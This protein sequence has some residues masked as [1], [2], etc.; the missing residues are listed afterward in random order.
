[1]KSARHILIGIMM[2]SS[3]TLYA[4]EYNIGSLSEEVKQA[5]TTSS[6]EEVVRLCDR[7][8]GRLKQTTSVNS[9]TLTRL[10]DYKA[11]SMRMLGNYSGAESCYKDEISLL[12]D[13]PTRVDDVRCKLGVLYTEMGL[14]GEAEETLGAVTGKRQKGWSMLHL[15]SLSMRR[16]D[17]EEAIERLNEIIGTYPDEEIQISAHQNLGFILMDSPQ[18]DAQESAKTHLRYAI[19]RLPQ[20]RLSY[21]T[22][23]GN[24]ALLEAKMGEYPA[25]LRHIN[26]AIEWYETTGKTSLTDYKIAIRKKGEILMIKGNRGEAAK[27]YR[28]Y[29]GIEK[30]FAI[31]RFSTMT[32]QNR[33]DF[34]KTLKPGVSKIFAIEEE[35]PDFL[36]DVSLF[37]REVTLLGDAEKSEMKRRL[38]ITGREITGALKRGEI[39]ID[40]VRYRKKD[41]EM[42][43]AIIIPSAAMNMPIKFLPLWEEEELHGYKIGNTLR[44]DEAMCSDYMQDKNLLYTDSTL[45]HYIWDALDREL[46]KYKCKDIYFVPD[47]ILHLLAI[48]YMRQDDGVTLHRIST[49]SRLIDRK[50]HTISPK[51]KMLAAGGLDFDDADFKEEPGNGINHDAMNYLQERLKHIDRPFSYLRGARM[52][53][54]S[55]RAYSAFDTD[56]TTL[57]TE[58]QLKRAIKGKKYNILHLSTHGY[59]LDV[60]VPEMPEAIRDS[61]TEDRSLLASGIALTGANVAYKSGSSEDGIISA[62]EFCEMDLRNIDLI[63]L[64]ACQTGLGRFSDEGPAG[65]VRGL[66]KGGAGAMIVSLW[67]VNDR[68]T[69]LF[70]KHLYMALRRQTEP[71][72]HTAFSRAREAFAKEPISVRKFDSKRMKAKRG[73]MTYGSPQYCNAFILIDGIK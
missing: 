45:S 32:E 59:A 38:S 62:R 33:L 50:E 71:D 5:Y 55:I 22:T 41:R 30:A 2:I 4:E 34:W 68:A 73:E 57:Q 18:R 67:S 27:I 24:L 66:K 8:I 69:M 35:C 19:D 65:L 7:A 51:S 6:Y 40:F 1:M 46:S 29:F 26:E 44:L 16:G 47:G 25:S 53:I 49:L 72:I 28:K 10:M 70:M 17:Q 14:Y 43:G 54:D 63:V 3:I 9:L 36:L 21:H 23:L 15:A 56:T 11:M 31:A 64:S 20:D 60:S 48:E 58:R 52:E 61:I 39:A 13:Y 42:Y 37:R 12:E